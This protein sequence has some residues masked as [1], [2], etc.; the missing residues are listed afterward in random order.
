MTV[1]GTL[2]SLSGS[3]IYYVLEVETL[4]SDDSKGKQFEYE[5]RTRCVV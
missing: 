1:L 3:I 2:C 4:P 5:Y